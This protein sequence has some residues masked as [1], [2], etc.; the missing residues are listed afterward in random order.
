MLWN[1]QMKQKD[2]KRITEQEFK[3]VVREVLGAKPPKKALYQNRKPTNAELNKKWK[4]V[5][6]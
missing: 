5:K 2:H 4:L 6:Q 3:E 1:I